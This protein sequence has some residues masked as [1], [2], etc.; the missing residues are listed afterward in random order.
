MGRRFASEARFTGVISGY[1]IHHKDV[2]F[3]TFSTIL[4]TIFCT[5]YDDKLQSATVYTFRSDIGTTAVWAG[6]QS[7]AGKL[8]GNDGLNRFYDFEIDNRNPRISVANSRRLGSKQPPLSILP[9]SY[10]STN[11]AV[12]S[13]IDESMDRGTVL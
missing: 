6:T 13:L 11:L 2:I 4:A 12:P 1:L 3:T 5:P 10:I 7:R 8:L 9:D